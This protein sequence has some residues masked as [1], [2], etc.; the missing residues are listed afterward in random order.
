ML[1][2]KMDATQADSGTK[3]PKNSGLSLYPLYQWKIIVFYFFVTTSVILRRLW[4]VVFN[5]K[6]KEKGKFKKQVHLAHTKLPKILDY[7][8]FSWILYICF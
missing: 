6:L 5:V 3:W 1:I 2:L 8:P 4:N 7:K